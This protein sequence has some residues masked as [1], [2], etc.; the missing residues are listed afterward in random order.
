[1]ERD[2]E[3][4]LAEIWPP[5]GLRIETPRLTLRVMRDSDIAAVV[6]LIDQGVHDPAVMPFDVPWTDMP[7]PERNWNSMRHWAGMR[8]SLQPD[9]WILEFLVFSGDQVVGAQALSGD[10]FAVR[11]EGTSGSWL[12][13][14]HQSRGYG[15]EMRAALLEFAFVHLGASA[16]N[17]AAYID[18]PKS[19]GVSLKLGY[20]LNGTDT[21][22]PRGVP[23]TGQRF[24][25]TRERWEQRRIPLDVQVAGLDTCRPLLGI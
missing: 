7:V 18:N 24:R 23:V 21:K 15:T 6:D 3:A 4:R 19:N 5:F 2:D 9:R 25:L 13:L 20:E 11:R 17:S 10:N 12:G 16:M 22:A 8:S 14:A 1:M